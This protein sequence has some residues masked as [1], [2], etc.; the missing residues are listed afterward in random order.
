MKHS[1]D[2]ECGS[3]SLAVISYSD[4]NQFVYL[5]KLVIRRN[6]HSSVLKEHEAWGLVTYTLSVGNQYVCGQSVVYGQTDTS[7]EYSTLVPRLGIDMLT[8][9]A[10]PI[11]EAKQMYR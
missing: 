3:D 10:Y 2:V 11:V 1:T 6:Y 4:I 9:I 7:Y 5:R 8:V